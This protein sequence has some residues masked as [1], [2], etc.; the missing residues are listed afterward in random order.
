[1][2]KM[3]F[4]LAALFFTAVSFSQGTITGT[5][6][7]AEAGGPLPGA[8]V[9]VQGTSNGVAT[10]FDG[11]FTIEV[12]QNSGT[13]VVSYLGFIVK[14]VKFSGP[15]NVGSISLEPNAEAL[16]G[17]VI[18]GSGVIDLAKERET[19]VA[20]ST[21]T[22]K[23]IQEKIGNQE[24]PEILNSTPSVYAT[25]EGGGYGDSR[26]NV[27]GFD[28]RNI[29]IIVNGQPVNDMENGWV[30]WSNWQG[31]SD[32]ASGI[33]IQRGLGASKLAVP[34]V[35]GT[36]NI[37]TKSTDKLEGGFV[38]GIVGNDAYIKTVAAYDTGLSDNGWAA[39]V[40][41][42]RWSGDG[43]ADG[44]K[45]E[46]YSYLFSLGYKPSDSHAF[47]FTF[48]GAAQWHN[49][50]SQNLSIRDYLNF[51]GDD[52]RRFNADWGNLNGE[53][54]SFRRN[55][56]NKPIGTLN[57]DWNINDNLSL[58]TA[59]YGSWGRGGG[60]GSRGRNFGI[61]PFR[62]DLTQ[63]IDDGDLPY[64][65][66]NG[67]IDFDAVV[68]NNKAGTPYTG[69]NS[70]Y[71][72]DIIG[73]NGY[74][75]DGVNSNIAI[76]RS[77]MNSHNW[78]G[79]I[80]N[81]KYELGDWTLGGGL[82]LR[83]YKGYHYRVL[84][85]LL[86]LD[87]YY[88]TGNKNLDT[89]VIQT[90]TIEATPFKDMGM[91]GAK[92]DY[93]NIGEVNWLGVNGIAEYRRDNLSGVLQAGLSDQSYRRIDYFDQPQNVTSDKAHKKGGYVKG[94]G[95]YNLDERQNVFFNIGY[96]SRQPIFDAI[97]PNFANDVNDNA[98][99]EN[100]FSVELGYGF[101]SAFINAHVNLYSTSWGNRFISRGVD[102]GAGVEG[103]AN[104]S[105]IEQLHNGIEI[106]LTSRPIQ[107]L[108]L[109]GMLSVGDWKYK[110]NIEASVFDD[111]QNLVGTSTLYL[112]DVKVGDAAQLTA[113]L[114]ADYTVIENLSVNANWRYVGNLYADFDIAND[115][116]FLTPNNPG[117]LKLPNY[118][119]FDLGAGYNLGFKNTTNLDFRLN[120]NNVFNTKYIAESNT[121]IHAAT[122][123]VL[124]DGIDDQ[125]EVWFGF[126]TTW[127]LGIRYNF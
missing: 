110:D 8:N 28:Q 68:A 99:N 10:D 18:V 71:T 91:G 109:N 45:G 19:P 38:G 74:N 100:I 94:G 52:F 7:D 72:G 67:L 77:S 13:L 42:G 44:T 81:L 12:W 20:V 84:N 39:S 63:A 36:I 116:N 90:E 4:F 35:G 122:D 53:E 127:N 98:E 41:L 112:E 47:N 24:F 6:V 16:E 17:V 93:Y 117:A 73:S 1:M 57:W 5:V 59:I 56:Y 22:A 97:Y 50:R 31:L 95:N 27:R 21:I 119:L 33:Q 78:F 86:G 124:Y 51:G 70:N 101:R 29:A 125:N 83:G 55:F 111:N 80:S 96:I 9:L 60:T 118:N 25:K 79:A 113:N 115:D 64:R 126:G 11:N 75:Q 105:G 15:G 37:V 30:Y 89:G 26:I 123:S 54:Y 103:T 82:D 108:R 62:K 88:S 92:I 32:V 49:Q 34:S 102:L 65:T 58:S 114:G 3:Y 48:T 69:G 2:N 106:E 85:D 23:Q 76:R 120:V 66:S 61:Y 87:A 121:N 104:Y 107:D 14:N 43:Y 46:G 40:L